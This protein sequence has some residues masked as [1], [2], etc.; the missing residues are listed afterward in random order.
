MTVERHLVLV[1]TPG[2]QDVQDFDNIARKVQELAPDIEVFIASND[3]PSSVTR[4]RAGRLP[5]LVFS[6]GKLLEFRPERGKIYAGS[7]IPKLEQIAR[8]RAS[9]LWSAPLK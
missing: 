8:F 7:P 3:I 4:R 2:F 6:P 5:T 1:H 9:G